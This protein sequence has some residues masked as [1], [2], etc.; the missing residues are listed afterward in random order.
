MFASE[1]D[2]F[3]NNPIKNLNERSTKTK[4]IF[5]N[6][7]HLLSFQT[8][9]HKQTRIHADFTNNAKILLLEQKLIYLIFGSY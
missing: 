2:L 9:K 3:V 5:D 8:K 4:I 7:N 1:M 6:I